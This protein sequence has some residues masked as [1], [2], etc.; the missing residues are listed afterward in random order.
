[1]APYERG[2]RRALQLVLGL[3]NQ[4]W[5]REAQPSIDLFVQQI[6]NCVLAKAADAERQ[7]DA[8]DALMQKRRG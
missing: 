5:P 8:I 4:A 3:S 1:L 6:R 7:H 2:Y